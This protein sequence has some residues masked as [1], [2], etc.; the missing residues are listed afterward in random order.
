M[1]FRFLY[2]M[3]RRENHVDIDVV[4]FHNIIKSRCSQTVERPLRIGGEAFREL[5]IFQSKFYCLM[6]TR[7]ALEAI[8]VR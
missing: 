8:S 3:L 5:E 2:F 7:I 4:F 6:D 1:P